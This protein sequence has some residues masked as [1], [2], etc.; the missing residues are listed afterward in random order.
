MAG[1]SSA[2]AQEVTLNYDRLA[3]LEE[4]IALE[5]GQVTIAVEG[6]LDTPVI[7]QYDEVTDSSGVDT[8]FIGNFQISAET[9]LANRW[10]IGAAYFGQYSTDPGRV[11]LTNFMGPERY[12]DNIAAFVQTSFG[13]VIA[14]NVNQQL[15]ELTRRQREVGNAF[16]ARDDF[17]GQI[18][19][20]GGAYI[21]RFGPSQIGLLVDENGDFEVGAVFE[22]PIGSRDVRLSG[23]YR[24]GRLDR[25]GEGYRIASSGIGA[26]GEIEYGRTITDLGLGVER[27]E[28]T[29]L[30]SATTDLTRAFISAGAQTQIGLLRVSGEGHYGR[31][32]SADEITAALGAAYDVARGLSLNLGLNYQ[33]TSLTIE[34]EELIA[35]EEGQAL[36]S[37]RFSF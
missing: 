3:S 27:L 24:E 35:I 25:L 29:P 36:A 12:N 1:A 23:R 26:V 7:A 15:R 22:R 16:L 11:F 37:V 6:V 21:G 18:G 19:R 14:G 10:T 8:A 5:I 32:G 20:W 17:I 13:A 33:N 31:L 34:E 28:V 30:G 2:S 4:P 9:Q